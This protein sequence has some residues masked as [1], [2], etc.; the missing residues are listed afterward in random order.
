MTTVSATA[1][2]VQTGDPAAPAASLLPA[3]GPA[4]ASDRPLQNVAD[5]IVVGAGVAGL[6]AAESLRR[7]NLSVIVL[8]ARERTGGRVFSDQILGH[9]L[10]LG[11]SWVKGVN[12]NPLVEGFRFRLE[13]MDNTIIFDQSFNAVDP[14][15]SQFFVNKIWE[16]RDRL[17]AHATG[18]Q[19]TAGPTP[20][21][22]RKRR[23]W[24]ER[25]RLDGAEAEGA[26]LEDD[27]PFDWDL[28]RDDPWTDAESPV[29]ENDGSSL[30]GEE[31]IYLHDQSV[32]DWILDDDQF[33]EEINKDLESR[34]LLLGLMNILENLEGAD[35]DAL[36]FSHHDRRD[37]SGPHLYVADSY[38]DFVA[39]LTAPLVA[40]DII[41]LGHIVVNIDYSGERGDSDHPVCVVTNNGN[42]FAKSVICTIPLGVLKQHHQSLFHPSLPYDTQSAIKRLG[43]GLIDKIVLEFPYAFWPNSLD[44]FWAFLP[45]DFRRGMDFDEGEDAPGLAGF[46]NFSRLRRK[47]RRESLY[48]NKHQ[49]EGEES[50]VS[51]AGNFASA[52]ETG[53]S[54]MSSGSSRKSSGGGG[55]G[56]ASEYGPPVLVAYVSQRHARRLEGMEDG[57]VADLFLTLLRS[58]FKGVEIPDLESIRVTRWEADPFSR[59]SITYIPTGMATPSDIETLARPISFSHPDCSTRPAIF[60]AGEHTSRHHFA[61]VHGA[62]ISGW[63]EAKAAASHLGA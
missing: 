1:T 33:L 10:D 28:N 15:R 7:S 6:A 2:T 59:G 57:E 26:D 52:A 35:L 60:F 49:G 51:T 63:R 31:R 18:Q 13:G 41:R 36:S 4:P 38:N 47:R 44:A 20:N 48:V 39:S 5:V 58:C 17:I 27:I 50:E 19:S 9:H 11:A 12:R 14:I 3:E 25:R 56:G 45:S 8:E 29:D 24:W 34:N 23:S 43:I 42:F 32:R 61:S 40:E 30:A 55:G 53:S 16:A 22:I 21:H 54:R 37:F 46:I 62:L